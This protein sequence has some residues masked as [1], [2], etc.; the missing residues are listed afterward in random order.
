MEKEVLEFD[1]HG[2]SLT[3]FSQEELSSSLS[4]SYTTI[5]WGNHPAPPRGNDCITVTKYL[6]HCPDLL[7]PLQAWGE[8]HPTRW[9]RWAGDISYSSI[10]KRGYF[11]HSSLGIFLLGSLLP[12]PPIDSVRREFL[13]LNWC[14]TGLVCMWLGLNSLLSVLGRSCPAHNSILDLLSVTFSSSS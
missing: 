4:P 7:D 11:Q 13:Q 14:T 5:K 2:S 12:S 8:F 10:I 9:N 3:S 6:Y 1:R